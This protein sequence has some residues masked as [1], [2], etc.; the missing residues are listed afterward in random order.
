[1][2]ARMT[3]RAP[4]APMR[5]DSRLVTLAQLAITLANPPRIPLMHSI[6]SVLPCFVTMLYTMPRVPPAREARVEVIVIFIAMIH[7]TPLTPK[8]APW[9]NAIQAHLKLVEIKLC[10]IFKREKKGTKSF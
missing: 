2:L 1:M 6:T 5:I 10:R 9:L 4:T 8:V 7:L 3:R